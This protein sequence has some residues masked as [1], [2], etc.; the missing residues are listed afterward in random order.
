MNSMAPSNKSLN[1]ELQI[2]SL[3]I[4]TFV[5]SPFYHSYCRTFADSIQH[6]SNHRSLDLRSSDSSTYKVHTNLLPSYAQ[7]LTA[8]S[9]I[10]SGGSPISNLPTSTNMPLS[11]SHQTAHTVFSTNELLCSI[12]THLPFYDIVAATSVCKSW[13]DALQADPSVKEALFLK[14]AKVHEVMA[15]DIAA[16]DTEKA[17]PLDICDVIGHFHPSLERI[18]G[19]IQAGNHGIYAAR[20]RDFPVFNHP[21]GIWREMLISQPP[22]K[23]ITLRLGCPPDGVYFKLF[24]G[25]END[26]GVKIGELYDF[27]HDN[28]YDPPNEG[29]VYL[30][31]FAIEE[32]M[33]VFEQFSTRCQ[34]RDC[35][36]QH[37]ATPP[38]DKSFDED[39]EFL[40]DYDEEDYLG[41][42]DEDY[43]EGND[44][45]DVVGPRYSPKMPK[46]KVWDKDLEFLVNYDEDDNSIEDD[47]DDEED[48]FDDG[49]SDNAVD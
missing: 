49:G 40:V 41:E 3:T 21:D 13:R 20:L 9:M 2:A 38:E 29:L 46:G 6:G 44:E 25:Y 30:N 37:P 36:V 48:N 27:I 10:P 4:T 17:I 1:P 14:P 45:G 39:L 15:D 32:D 35:V 18:C 47:D 24:L 43:D 23:S 22:C 26:A 33:W 16:G 5:L 31:D 7:L 34:V 11:A 42:S 8:Y 19:S 28:K 12:V